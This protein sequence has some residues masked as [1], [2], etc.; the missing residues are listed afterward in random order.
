MNLE[1]LGALPIG[2]LV[3]FMIYLAFLRINGHFKDRWTM[4]EKEAV[5]KAETKIE[6]N[7]TIFRPMGLLHVGDLRGKN[8][9][10]RDLGLPGSFYACIMYDP[11]RYADDKTKSSQIKIDS[12]SSCIH[13]IGATVS[14]GITS[15]PT[16]K[17]IQDSPELMRLKHLLPDDRIWRKE[18][19]SDASMSY[20]ILQP[21][22]GGHC[23]DGTGISLL[24][25]EQSYGAIVIQVRFSDVLGSFSLFDNVIGE[26]V[27]PLAKLAGSGRVVEGWFRLLSV[28]TTDTVPGE[29]PVTTDENTDEFIENAGVGREQIPSVSFPELHVEVKFSSKSGLA[30]GTCS[31]D[32]M[33]SFKVIC[34]E[35]SRTASIAQENSVGM[36]GS[37]LN[38]INTVRTLGGQLQNQLSYVLDMLE[39]VRNAFNFSVSELFLGDDSFI[40]ST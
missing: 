13:Q 7:Q 3:M 26:V 29:S 19:D 15:N 11:L 31:S 2:C 4:Q 10:S 18:K 30:D 16:W 8:L 6:I 38:T 32:N 24:P 35:I 14:S 25:W 34:E 17:H 22:T 33:E 23:G 9:R 37:S 28:G 12:S 36:I 21:V 1:Y 40:F 5:I 20:P 27:I 39:R